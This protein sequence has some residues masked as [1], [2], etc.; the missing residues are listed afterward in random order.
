MLGFALRLEA[1]HLE[2]LSPEE[3]GLILTEAQAIKL[4]YKSPVKVNAQR[5]RR[6]R[7]AKARREPWTP[8]SAPTGHTP[9][10]IYREHRQ[11]PPPLPPGFSPETFDP[12]EGLEP[13][14]RVVPIPPGLKW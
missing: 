4:G 14:I 5:I 3:R 13:Y 12:R 11:S 2:D 9:G 7:E 10:N 8:P 1:V 6:F